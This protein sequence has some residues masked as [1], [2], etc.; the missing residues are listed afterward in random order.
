MEI[1]GG[2]AVITPDT[3]RNGPSVPGMP[4]FSVHRVTG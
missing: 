3:F 1:A 4:G 2:F